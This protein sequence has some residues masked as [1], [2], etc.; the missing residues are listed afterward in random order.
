MYFDDVIWLEV[1]HVH[2]AHDDAMTYGLPGEDRGIRDLGL[3][4]SAVMAP[5][6]AYPDTLGEIAASYV[7]GLVKNHGYQNSNKRTG[8]IALVM[9]LEMNG[10]TVDLRAKRRHGLCESRVSSGS[11]SF[12]V[13]TTRTI[14]VLGNRWCTNSQSEPVSSFPKLSCI[15]SART[16]PVVTVTTRS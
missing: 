4:V 1:E 13:G 5:R 10:F 2:D 9:F 16:N 12:R 7:F 6:N 14:S 11:R 15:A 8:A 3:I